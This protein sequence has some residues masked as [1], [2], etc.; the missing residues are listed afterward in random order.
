M[1][2]NILITPKISIPYVGFGTYKLTGE[3]C[4]KAVE[5]AL[6]I[7]YRHIDTAQYYKNEEEVGIAIRNSGLD[8]DKVFVTTK[9]FP[10][11][12]DRFL[13]ATEESLKRF[14]T[15][16]VDLLLLHWPADDEM[17]K[18]AVDGLNMALYKGYAK[19]IGVSNFNIEKLKVALKMAPVVCNQVEYHPY[20]SQQK[21]LTFMKEHHIFMTAY[22]P[23]AKG[24]VMK[25]AVL[26]KL[27]L[28][29][30]KNI[31]QV[32]LRWL[33]QQ[34]DIAV[35]PKATATERITENLNVFDFVLSDEDMGMIS[36]LSSDD[37][38][39][40]PAWSPKWD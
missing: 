38:I 30:K 32:V 33:L 5:V 1:A 11:D 16:H 14:K 23:L 12:Y 25:D 9:I 4:R 7:G 22:S 13:K 28:K 3:T 29:Y 18:K 27:A 8:R 24:K 19:N 34:G 31:S 39:T 40:N 15:D 37:R 36:G 35:I 20:I 17:T 10:T 26:E 2:Q 21:L 6:Q